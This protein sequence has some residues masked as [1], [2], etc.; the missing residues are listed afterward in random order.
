MQIRKKKYKNHKNILKTKN[1][2]LFH[3]QIHFKSIQIRFKLS[4]LNPD[5]LTQNLKPRSLMYPL[6]KYKGYPM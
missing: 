5:Q 6:Y 2:A 4:Y 3:F 1:L